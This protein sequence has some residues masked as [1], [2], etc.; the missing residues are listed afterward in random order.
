MIT[1]SAAGALFAVR[2]LFNALPDIMNIGLS[3]VHDSLLYLAN[4][5]LVP[6]TC[7]TGF[8]LLFS[9][10]TKPFYYRVI[11][12]ALFAITTTAMALMVQRAPLILCAIGCLGIMA[13]RTTHTP[14]K[15]SIIATI[16][17]F[18]SIPFMTIAFQIGDGL[19]EKTITV[20]ANNRIDEII[21]A[22][23][24]TTLF[25][26]GWGMEW[27]SPAVADYWVR[28]THNMTTYYW[29][30]AGVIGAALS[31]L[32]I[33]IWIKETLILTRHNLAIGIAIIISISIHFFLYT[34]YKTFDIS[35]LLALIIS[36]KRDRHLSSS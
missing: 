29:L 23:S 9:P 31:I 32:F 28:Y 27:Q 21:A 16:L 6:F 7:I 24:H 18:I 4:S 22:L 33:Y 1:L 2:Y 20:G 15:T 17:L 10:D 34:G 36:C 35:L 12:F 30:K 11:G 8:A 19:I 3:P 25:G 14:L 13:V 5:P 26:H